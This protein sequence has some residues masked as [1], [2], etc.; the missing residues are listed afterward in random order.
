MLRWEIAL[1]F[2]KAFSIKKIF[3]INERGGKIDK[4]KERTRD[5]YWNTVTA[6]FE[7]E[8]GVKSQGMLIVLETETDKKIGPSLDF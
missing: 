3:F 6:G 8:R 7:D 5:R 2:S 1:Y 4:I